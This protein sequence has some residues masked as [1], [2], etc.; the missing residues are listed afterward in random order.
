MKHYTI[1]ILVNVLFI[2]ASNYLQ[3]QIIP[4]DSM[5]LGQQRPGSSPRVFELGTP[6]NFFNAERIAISSDY[7]KIF[8]QELDGYSEIDG[9]PHTVRMKYFEYR[10]NKWQGPFDFLDSLSSPSYS[11]TGDTM[12]V[13]KGIQRAYILVKNGID[14]KLPQRIL[15]KLKFVHYIQVTRNGNIY[16]SGLPSNTIGGLDFSK[17]VIVGKDTVLQSLG[18]PLSTPGHNF[19]FFVHP[20]EKYMIVTSNSGLAVSFPKP[21]GRWTNPKNLGSKINFGLNEW[22]PYVSADGHYLF[23]TAGTKMDYSDTRIHWV[24]ISSLIDSLRETPFQPYFVD[25]I[26]SLHAIVGKE[27]HFT[28]PDDLVIDDNPN[29]VLNYSLQL[30]NDENLPDWLHFTQETKTLTG[31]ISNASTIKLK[32]SVK[33]SYGLCVS[34]SFDVIASSKSE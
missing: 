17:L 31:T 12:F 28:I 4:L 23:Y 29:S 6:A 33:N 32:L 11:C 14:W 16:L 22:G 3:A 9:K 26:P 15:S 8:F 27:F 13:Q 7:K 24:N 1:L 25:Q 34:S 18:R 10:Q 5:F 20:D 2:I 19:D 30:Q 21:D